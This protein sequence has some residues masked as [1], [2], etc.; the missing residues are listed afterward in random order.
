[1][2]NSN[3]KIGAA[4]LGAGAAFVGIADSINRGLKNSG[5]GGFAGFA[6]GDGNESLQIDR[7]LRL[8]TLDAT[9]WNKVYPYVFKVVDESAQ[10]RP[11]LDFITSPGYTLNKVVS[12]DNKTRAEDF[13]KDPIVLPI[14]PSNISITT[15][16]A[17]NLTATLN[18]IIE[19]HNGAPFR[20]ITITGTMGVNPQRISNP[21]AISNNNSSIFQKIAQA[22]APNFVQNLQNLINDAADNTSFTKLLDTNLLST[23]IPQDNTLHTGYWHFHNLFNFIDAYLTLKKDKANKSK[24]L[25]FEMHKDQLFYKCSLRNF[26]FQKKP[27][28][29]E[30]EYTIQLT[31]WEYETNASSLSLAAKQANQTSSV[32]AVNRALGAL[33]KARKLVAD[34]KD[35]VAGLNQDVDSY[36]EVVREGIMLCK[37][38]LGVAYTVADFPQ[39]IV[40]D[41]QSIVV[42]SWDQLKNTATAD[43]VLAAKFTALNNKTSSLNTL[44]NKD[45]ST[46]DVLSAQNAHQQDPTIAGI[47]N[48]PTRNLDFFD[49]IN[50]DALPTPPA[51]K[52]R[53]NAEVQR[54]RALDLSYFITQRENLLAQ[55]A[56]IINKLGA[57]GSTYNRIQGYNFS[58]TTS[59]RLRGKNIEILQAISEAI[60]ALNTV[61]VQRRKQDQ[62]IQN[63]SEFY[64]NL[65]N[66]NGLNLTQP[67]SKFPI[68]FPTG[69]SLQSLAVRYLGD[70]NRWM[71]IAAI[72]GLKAP[73]V[74]EDGFTKNIIAATSGK[75]IT[76]TDA[77]D[78]YINQPIILTGT[79]LNPLSAKIKEIN[80]IT[81]AQTILTLDVD[82]TGYGVDQAAQMQ[83]Y[84]PGT[85][86]SNM[87]IYIPSTETPRLITDSFKLGAD[88][89]DQSVLSAIA[90]VDFMLTTS[91]DLAITSRGDIRLAMGTDNLMQAAKLKLVTPLGSLLAYPGYGLGVEPGTSS[92]L[93]DAQAAHN[94]LQQ[95][96]AQDPRYSGILASKINKLG[97]VFAINLVLGLPNTDTTLPLNVNLRA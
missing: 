13:I 5:L 38:S 62:A 40:K 54:V 21:Q 39:A 97:S 11:D 17:S 8:Y 6:G 77:D 43:D 16:V 1:M 67:T 29:L 92:A 85:V 50:L 22:V 34:V 52:Q 94:A 60:K 18:G 48:D 14:G 23:G 74:D 41:T 51:L 80:Q 2:A 65:A 35:V 20:Q 69:A 55:E 83:A 76:V 9:R 32:S 58:T 89:S 10:Q 28:T 12:S 84:L 47:F 70:V 93:V 82:A 42:S 49:S 25:V 19:E 26:S 79:G 59:N 27:G 7:F 57:D 30:Y 78:L 72:N 3:L 4:A 31:G 71:E 88:I 81:A 15:L 53:M 45:I 63:Y 64:V 46:G 95:S 44:N 90:G 91:G 96:F 24:Y 61:I 86:N 75:L 33:H 68:P 56:S 36:L 66:A 87:L 73:Y 37:D